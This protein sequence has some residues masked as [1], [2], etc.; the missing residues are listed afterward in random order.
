MKKL[1]SLPDSTDILAILEEE[2]DQAL[3][4]SARVRREGPTY[5]IT[6]WSLVA[7][8]FNVVLDRITKEERSNE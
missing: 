3:S 8:R 6:S 1:E 4:E 2:R 7:E 5:L